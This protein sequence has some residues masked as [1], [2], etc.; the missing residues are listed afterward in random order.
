VNVLWLQIVKNLLEA[1][2]GEA[3]SEYGLKNFTDFI[4]YQ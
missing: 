2:V 4:K 3:S 1:L